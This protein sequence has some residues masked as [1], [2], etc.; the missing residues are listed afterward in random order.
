MDISES[1][2][3]WRQEPTTRIASARYSPT[4]TTWSD[5]YSA[6]PRGRIKRCIAVRQSVCSVLYAL[7]ESECRR[8]LK[9]VAEMGRK[10]SS[11]D[12][13]HWGHKIVFAHISLSKMDRF[14]S[15]QYQQEVK[16]SLG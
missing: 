4:P 10:L 11:K 7:L 9:F 1:S 8:N 12:Q 2:Q 15:N 16:L 13:G 5:Y 3:R 14:T 6:F